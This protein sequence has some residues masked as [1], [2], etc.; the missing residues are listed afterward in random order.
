MKH[1]KVILLGIGA[2]LLALM[3][4]NMQNSR[5]RKKAARSK[6]NLNK[7]IHESKKTKL[8]DD[9]IRTNAMLHEEKTRREGN[10]KSIKVLE[11]IKHKELSEIHFVENRL[12]KDIQEITD[13]DKALEASKH[14]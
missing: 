7:E 14:L 10:K 12:K 4:L 2:V 1:L 5:L 8:Q 11:A 9:F 6:A 3:G 13:L